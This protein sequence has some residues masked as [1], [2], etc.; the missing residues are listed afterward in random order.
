MGLF[1]IF[2]F[3]NSKL[4]D[5]IRSGA[6]VID[7]RTA[8][9]FDQGR[10]PS[11]INIP[12]DRIAVSAERIRS[13]NRPIIFVCSTGARSN[14]AARIMKEKGLKDV[15]NGGNWEDLLKLLRK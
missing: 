1:S 13:M 7:V 15:Y 3:G 8:T 11:S 4:K 5:A 12:V 2:G 6:I 14:T 10:V 9:E